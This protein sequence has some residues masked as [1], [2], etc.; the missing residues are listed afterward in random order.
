VLTGATGFLGAHL[1]AELLARTDDRVVCPVRADDASAAARRLREALV[2]QGLP[3]TGL[4]DR[5]EAVPADLARPGLGLDPDQLADL[6]ECDAIYH[7]AAVISV[8]R[9][10]PSLRGV[11][12][13]GTRQM[14]RLAAVRGVPLHYVSTLNVAPPRTVRSEVPEDFLPAHPGLRDGYQQSKWAAER[15]VE[16]AAARG[17]PVTVHRLARLVGAA[18]TGYVNPEDLLWRVLRVGIPLGAIPLL[19]RA[20]AWTPVDFVARA[21]VHLSR[22]G[23]ATVH[24]LVP[25]P[26]LPLTDLAAWINDYGYPVTL[27]PLDRWRAMLPD[28]AADITTLAFFDL[29]SGGDTV[30]DLE[31]GRLVT[32]NMTRGLA[33]T[34]IACPPPD[35]DLMRRYLDHCVRTGLL[36][37]PG[38]AR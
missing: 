12:V 27:E 32:D 14:L 37:P 23:G 22:A 35:A 7:N 29:W 31:I 6:A 20:D 19:Y 17:L 3:P 4:D 34:G 21:I 18:G 15:L 13:H 30:T 36:P 1:L 38:G 10:Y 9:E 26:E 24:N 5:V 2:A 28:A 8:M 11:N 16:Q 33:G 25:H